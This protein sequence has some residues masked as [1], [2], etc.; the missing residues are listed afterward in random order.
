[1]CTSQYLMAD[2]A[3]TCPLEP[4]LST[5]TEAMTTIRSRQRKHR[6]KGRKKGRKKKHLKG[7]KPTIVNKT[8]THKQHKEYDE[9][10]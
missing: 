10:I 8:I 4:T 7:V 2:V 1:M 5:M 3:N 6:K 9:R